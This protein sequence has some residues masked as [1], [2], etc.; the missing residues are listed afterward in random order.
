MTYQATHLFLVCCSGSSPASCSSSI[1][2]FV[3]A[4]PKAEARA[5]AV[6]GGGD[7]V[8]AKRTTS[9]ASQTPIWDTCKIHVKYQDTCIHLECNRACKIRLGYIKIH[10]D[11]CIHACILQDTRRDCHQDTY[12]IGNVPKDDRKC[13]LS[14]WRR[15]PRELRPSGAE[16]VRASKRRTPGPL[17]CTSRAIRNLECEGI[18]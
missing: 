9:Q 17:R 7:R 11:T 18:C 8:T 15:D 14:P 16:R 13:T 10:Q 12:L 1:F 2:C 5:A 4:T 6:R 3:M